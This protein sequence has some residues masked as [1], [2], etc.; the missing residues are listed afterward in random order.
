LGVHCGIYKSSCNTPTWIHLLH[1][2]PLPL[3]KPCTCSLSIEI[4]SMFRQD[5]VVAGLRYY[6][7]PLDWWYGSVAKFSPTCSGYQA[8]SPALLNFVCE[9]YLHSVSIFFIY[10]HY[11]VFCYV[12]VPQLSIL[13]WWNLGLSLGCYNCAAMSLAVICM[14]SCWAY[15]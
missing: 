12:N 8:W 1:H 15:S 4:F 13:Y 11:M 3:P 14:H 10:S 9:G 2:S 7:S 5:S 6:F